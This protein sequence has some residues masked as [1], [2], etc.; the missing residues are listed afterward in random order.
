MARRSREGRAREHLGD[1]SIA[2]RFV[3]QGPTPNR[4]KRSHLPKRAL[5]FET[6]QRKK[7][8]LRDWSWPRG[9]PHQGTPQKIKPLLTWARRRSRLGW[10]DTLRISALALTGPSC[11]GLPAGLERNGEDSGDQCIMFRGDVARGNGHP[12]PSR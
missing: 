9:R 3:L 11:E 4:M 6:D 8:A 12:A 10:H 1:H 5:F 7:K 2:E